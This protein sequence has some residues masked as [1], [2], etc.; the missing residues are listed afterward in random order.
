MF[1]PL[2]LALLKLSH[3]ARSDK[4]QVWKAMF[5]TFGEALD[6]ADTELELSLKS[7]DFAEGVSHFLEKRKENFSDFHA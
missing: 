5:Q 2:R 1:R 3:L 4:A 6:V 7:Q